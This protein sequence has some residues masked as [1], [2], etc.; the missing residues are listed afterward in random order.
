MPRA[1]YSLARSSAWQLRQPRVCT[2]VFPRAASPAAVARRRRGSASVFSQAASASA[3]ASASPKSGI[4]IQA[5][6][7]FGCFRNAASA[8]GANLAPTPASEICPAL[9]PSPLVT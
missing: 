7:W 4:R 8:P 2:S 3:S 1:L 5:K 9:R 6:C